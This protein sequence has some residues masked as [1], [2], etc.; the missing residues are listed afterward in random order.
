MPHN[1]VSLGIF[2]MQ[3][4]K[5]SF[6]KRALDLDVAAEEILLFC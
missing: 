5:G 6:M 4:H 3:S 2:A 1:L